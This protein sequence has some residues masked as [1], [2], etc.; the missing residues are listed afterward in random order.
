MFVMNLY[1]FID[2]LLEVFQLHI[3]LFIVIYN[4]EAFA[5]HF[6]QFFKSA[7]RMILYKFFSPLQNIVHKMEPNRL[8]T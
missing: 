4:S 6:F 8:M 3:D 1:L 2:L 5:K 7:I